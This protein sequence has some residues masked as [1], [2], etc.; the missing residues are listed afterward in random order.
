MRI[1]I[2][3][4]TGEIGEGMAMRL[5]R[6]MDVCVGSRD[7][8]KAQE[9]CDVCLFSAKENKFECS[10]K[11]GSNQNVVDESD[12]IILAVPFK[13]VRSTVEGLT[14]WEDKIV[15]SPVNPMERKESF[16]YTP[17]AEG[18]AALYLKSILPASTR[19]CTAFNNIAGNKWRDIHSDLTY[20]VPVCGDDAQ[21]K[22][23]VMDLVDRIS[24]LKAY[25]AGP[26][27]G[28]HIVESIT[29]LLLNV[30]RYNRMKD[31]GIRFV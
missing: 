29:P 25:D 23:I 12:L 9:T 7:V 20:S 6:I 13:H 21:A 17:P 28:S 1:G 5:S 3:G 2:I 14:G 11:G 15:I 18:S 31:V 27:S 26:L 4:G 22:Q 8:A 19:I 30:A 10:V 16:V 24:L